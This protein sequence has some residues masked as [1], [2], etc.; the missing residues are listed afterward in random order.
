MR[1]ISNSPHKLRATYNPVSRTALDE[2]RLPAGTF[3]E[4]EHRIERFASEVTRDDRVSTGLG[5]TAMS[6]IPVQDLMN[7]QVPTV[8]ENA[9][10]N[11]A[12]IALLEHGAAEV[13]VVS[14]TGLLLGVIPEY[15][16]LKARLSGTPREASIAPI[17][18]HSLQTV[19][20]SASAV[21]V[22]GLFRE[23]FRS[24]LAVVDSSGR[25]IGQIK[26]RELIWLLTTLDRLEDSDPVP[27]SS[28]VQSTGGD[29]NASAET[30][31]QERRVPE[32]KFLRRKRV[33]GVEIAESSRKR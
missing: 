28:D 7:R 14:R 27:A 32:P 2:S 20:P 18:T 6:Q 33:L 10:I 5:R 1:R 23:G 8:L 4:N 17:V 26:R 29:A 13:Y 21:V 22:A 11:E 31:Q 9:S 30:S 16:I 19:A 24:S 12:A 25:L 15:E 3:L